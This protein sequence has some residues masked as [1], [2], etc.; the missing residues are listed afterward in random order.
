MNASQRF[1]AAAELFLEMREVPVDQ[2]ESLLDRK[3]G[4]DAELRAEVRRLINAREDPSIFHTLAVQLQPIHRNL[5]QQLPETRIGSSGAGA[6]PGDLPPGEE[7]NDAIGS[8]R[9]L[10]LIG[11]GGFGRVWVAEQSAP[12]RRRVALKIIKAGM[13]SREVL[14]R[15][16][17]ERQTLA[18]M[19]HPNVAKVFDAGVTVRGRPYFVMEHVPGP[20]IT[21]FCDS[22]RLRVRQRLELFTPVC[23]AVHHAHQ[24][25]IIH[26]DLKP[27]NI[28]VTLIDGR[29]LPKVID[30]GI[31]KAT[32]S[33][34]DEHTAYTEIGRL[35][36]TPEYMS[37]EQAAGGRDIDTRSD[38]YSLG[39]V[40]YQMLTGT[41]PFDG[42]TLRE[43]GSDGIARMIRELDPPKPST[44]FLTLISEPVTHQAGATPAEIASCHGTDMRSLQRELRGDLDWIV[45]KCLEK[46]RARRYESAGE[47][48]RDVRRYL[49]G[50][51]V[52]AAP[53]SPTY[54]L[55]KLAR[56][57][58]GAIVAAGA[59]LATLIAGLAVSLRLFFQEREAHDR[60]VAAESTQT[61]LREQAEDARVAE[62]QQRKSAETERD[63]ARKES[64]KATKINQFL[65]HMLSAIQP[66]RARGQRELTVRQVLDEAAAKIEAGSLRDEPEV[67]AAVRTTIGSMYDRLGLFDRAEQYLS[68]ALEARR[69]LLGDEHYDTLQSVMELASLKL[70]R[71]DFLSAEALLRPALEIQPKMLG[72]G[73]A[74]V[75]SLRNLLGEACFALGKLDEAE[76]LLN[77]ALQSRRAGP[78]NVE[79]AHALNSLGKIRMQRSD[80]AAAEALWREA[81]ETGLKAAGEDEVAV[82]TAY[83]NL[84]ALLNS[85]GDAAGAVENYRKSLRINRRLLAPEHPEIARCLR[86]L[87]NSLAII[88]NLSEAEPMYREA[89]DIQRRTLD[90]DH[91]QIATTLE[92]FGATLRIMGKLDEAAA[93]TREALAMRRRAPAE[94]S[95]PLSQ[96][97]FYFGLV[98]IEQG[99]FD[100]AESVFREALDLRRRTL[101]MDDD[102]VAEN[103]VSLGRVLCKRGDI[104]A[105]EPLIREGLA[106]YKRLKGTHHP[107]IAVMT[108]HLA[109]LLEKKDDLDGAEAAYREAL[110]LLRQLDLGERQMAATVMHNLACLLRNRERPDEAA[111]L[112][113]AALAIREKIL[114]PDHPHTA[115]TRKELSTLRADNPEYP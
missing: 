39:V 17:M 83:S 63:R 110:D 97:L 16:E 18:V 93:M 98:L 12:V 7:A 72:E 30:F 8:F 84:A 88:G 115:S 80:Y 100:E 11:E 108:S 95:L 33:A 104:S 94:G 35:M 31:A 6:L 75:A 73:H 62:S 29:P 92:N 34:L 86:G 14:A 46:D 41:L 4:N 21:N 42:R 91:P 99:Q 1:Q 81:L 40:L 70:D 9:L 89:L 74:D 58:R 53:P 26:R 55:T 87:A 28:L 76:S 71:E 79:M 67:D 3:C 77:K 107:R 47:L 85:R 52:V 113:R 105:A 90:A 109:V 38:V 37:P 57:H 15:F 43:A 23:D 112:F 60:A 102:L 54:R 5:R 69:G 64:A 32:G 51:A 50:E 13:D 68:A 44:R 48:A 103:L 59:V 106:L 27:S 61:A 19:D 45:M 25:G 20:S 24:K 36:G 78:P 114:P 66:E 56:R 65:Q 2:I 111:A 10:E 96:T 49:D 22:S 82:A 101:G